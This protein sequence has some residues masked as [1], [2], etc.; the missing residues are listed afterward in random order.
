ML[1]KI[2]IKYLLGYVRISIEGYYIERFINLCTTNK[3]LL[4]YKAYKI[5]Y[6]PLTKYN[7]FIKTLI[8]FPLD[9]TIP[10]I[11]IKIPISNK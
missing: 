10:M 9:Q 2:L 6:V 1:I 7:I 3:I 4:K 11:D 5:K 8:Q